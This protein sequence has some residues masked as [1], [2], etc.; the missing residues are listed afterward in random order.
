MKKNVVTAFSRSSVQ[1]PVV[2]LA[3]GT[4]INYI[5]TDALT[6]R[7]MLDE[8][9]PTDVDTGP[10]HLSR[11]GVFDPKSWL[12][13]A[14]LNDHE[15]NLYLDNQG[16]ANE[17][18]YVPQ[19]TAYLLRDEP[20]AAIRSFYSLM[21][22]GFSN[23]Q[24]TPLEHRW[25]HPQYYGPPSTDGAWFEIYR[26]MLIHEIGDDTLMIGQAIPRVWLEN[27]KQINVKNAP[28]YFGE[29]SFSIKG[30]SDMNVIDATIGLS[31]R[32][33]PKELWIRF[34][35]PE[36]KPIR[37]VIVNGQPW[38]NFDIEKE[39]IIISEPDQNTYVISASY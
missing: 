8:W 2:Q 20:K 26:K 17:P 24:L 13:T 12:T 37:S 35:H 5:P 4:W 9:Y 7:R 34:R 25:A 36:E 22:C 10:L 14:M 19:A 6:S 27:G 16:A 29:I 23:G 31:D 21:A 15:D 28:T 11:L 1:S 3:D 32:N 33:P 39:T 38:E 18:I 30:I